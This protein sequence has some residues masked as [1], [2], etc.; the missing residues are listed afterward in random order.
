M[1]VMQPMERYFHISSAQ[2]STW[3]IEKQRTALVNPL[4]IKILYN[5]KMQTNKQNNNNNLE[6]ATEKHRKIS[7]Q[8]KTVGKKKNEKKSTRYGKQSLISMRMLS[9]KKRG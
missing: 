7:E 9:S 1:D 6:P 3:K 5:T 8:S 2:R 4:N